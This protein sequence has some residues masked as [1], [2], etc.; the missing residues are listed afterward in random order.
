MRD[1]RR[2]ILHAMIRAT[3]MLALASGCR[4][5]DATVAHGTPASGA[6]TTP[7]PFQV[8]ANATDLIFFWFDD[9]GGVHA[10]D[11]VGDVPTERRAGVRVDP[12]RPEQRVAG[13]IYLADLR[14][15]NPDGTYPVRAVSAEAL[16]NEIVHRMG[17]GTQGTPVEVPVR[18]A[19]D[20][21]GTVAG[22]PLVIVY[23]A[24]W[25][26]ACHQAVAYLQQ[27]HIPFVEKDIEREPGAQAE[28]AAKAQRAGVQTGSIPIIDVRGHILVGFSPAAIEQALA[29]G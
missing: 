20:G 7:V 21:G 9:D 26:G 15:A 23:G 1:P 10:V 19:P 18:A 3:G 25:C 16:S 17:I 28:M 6:A 8:R 4:H 13:T 24:S 14:T 2:V 12:P 29:G 22:S 5:P 27:H 11:T